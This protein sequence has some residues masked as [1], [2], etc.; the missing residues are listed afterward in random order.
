MEGVINSIELTAMQALWCDV[1]GLDARMVQPDSHFLLLG[2]D[3]LQLARLLEQVRIVFG[4]FLPLHD[5]ARFA[6]PLRMAECCRAQHR[7]KHGT[8]ERPVSL[9]DLS[10]VR[11]TPVQ[12]GIWLAEQLAAPCM[13]YLAS[14]LVHLHGPLDVPALEL[15]VSALFRRFP[16]LRARIGQ[17]HAAQELRLCLDI[18]TARVGELEV[19]HCSPQELAAEAQARSLLPL[20]LQQGPLCR[21]QLYRLAADQHALLVSCHHTISDGWSGS[22]LLAQLADYYSTA[23]QHGAIAEPAPDLCFL[24]RCRREGSQLGA[25]AEERLCW[26]QQR[27]SGMELVQDWLWRRSSHC[28]PWPHAVAAVS[29]TLP[30]LLVAALRQRAMTLQHSLFTLFLYA[31]KA[32]LYDCSGV[33]RQILLVPV[34]QR[35]HDEET[36]IGCYIEPL[37]LAGEWQAGLTVATALQIEADG[38]AAA[39]RERV[40][41]A[42]L[43][44]SLR[45]QPLP[46]GNPWSS[47]L[48]AFQSFP[49]QQLQ[50]HALRYEIEPVPDRAS[51]YALKL[52]VLRAAGAWHLRME[53]SCSVLDQP[54]VTALGAAIM[55]H[56]CY[57]Q[58]A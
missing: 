13:L 2:G 48:F 38:F 5:L 40:P 7:Q 22:I 55:R 34:A 8:L 28:E 43:V 15:A 41:L 9:A 31:V 45:P 1:L 11:A 54:Q 44:R 30:E 27:L 10:E 18:A 29:L 50:W 52:E 4:V 56:L 3:S 36:S 16:V 42:T 39:L 47:I 57:L 26:W 35:R 49:Q 12:Q 33:A 14:V 46:D 23:V 53:Y 37:L 6:T 20:C 58:H 19:L 32:A 21:L 17:N 51:Q 24:E 25:A